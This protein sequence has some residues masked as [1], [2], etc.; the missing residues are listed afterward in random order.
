MWSG[1]DLALHSSVTVFDVDCAGSSL[2][3]RTAGSMERR[4]A[5]FYGGSTLLCRRL[6]RLW[7]ARPRRLASFWGPCRRG[8]YGL[9]LRRLR[10]RVPLRRRRCRRRTS[11]LLLTCRS[12]F[13]LSCL[14]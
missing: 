13:D 9:R 3:I 11:M 10:R 2:D 7:V 8:C 12:G 6:A 5:V 14:I 1:G 4:H